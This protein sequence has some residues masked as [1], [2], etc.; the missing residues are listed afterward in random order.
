MTFVEKFQH[1]CQLRGVAPTRALIDCGFHPSLYAKWQKQP[2]RMPY[3]DTVKRLCDYFG[4]PYGSLETDSE[5]VSKSLDTYTILNRCILAL[6]KADRDHLLSYV[7]F[8]YG[9]DLP[10][11]VQELWKTAH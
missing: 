4:C 5:S 10:D 6:P 2:E 7:V 3:G 11:E 9:K 8:T 1:Q